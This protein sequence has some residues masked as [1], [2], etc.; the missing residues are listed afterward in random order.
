MDREAIRKD[1]ESIL[2]E[3]VDSVRRKIEDLSGKFGKFQ[4]AVRGIHGK[5]GIS[6]ES[7]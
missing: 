6:G 7:N 1:L 3:S 4:F 5:E 2:M